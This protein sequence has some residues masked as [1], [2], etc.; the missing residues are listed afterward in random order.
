MTSVVLDVGKTNVRLVAMD[1]DGAALEILT[2]ENHVVA[3]PPYPHFDVDAIF[4]WVTSG[5][6]SLARR[7]D[8]DAI[9]PVAHG[10]CGAAI[11]PD[12]R[13][14][15]PVLDYEHPGPLA[16]E[17]YEALARRFDETGSPALPDGLNLGR[18]FFWLAQQHPAFADTRYL[19]PY[20]QYWAHRLSGVAC[21][22]ATSL[23]CHTDLWN[24]RTNAPSSFTLR[25]GWDALLPP[26]VPAWSRIGRVT[27]DV[28]RTTGLSPRCAVLAGI[29][30]SNA[31]YLCH[32]AT[33]AD[34]FAVVSSGTWII[35]MSR[36]G[37]LDGLP[38]ERD[39]LVNVDAFGDPVPT[40]RFMGGREYRTLAGRDALDVEPRFDDVLALVARGTLPLPGF[41]AHGGPFRDR[42]GRIE[43]EA[44]SE[45]GERAALASL[46]A[47]LVTDYCLDLVGASGDAV[48][49]GRFARNP[50]Y[51][52]VLAAL[53]APGAVLRSDDETGTLRGAAILARWPIQPE[54]PPLTRCT[55]SAA[56]PLSDYRAR[57]RQLAER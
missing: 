39:T 27:A 38:A 28:A 19:L 46:Y 29:H 57:W 2:T 17:G 3:G 53:R 1:D 35:V 12:G 9:V 11:G 7:F 16:A 22:E 52:T 44:P 48:V 30:D 32:R 49:E 41:T 18:Q 43:G 40:A 4:A 8:V 36:G 6:A 50:A 20:P 56:A 14:V 15:L 34:P 33:R 5:L 47:A 51:T 54:P 37:K 24:S 21:C 13:L 31:S 45:P 25:Q 23:G 26:L 55:P 42:E 10:A